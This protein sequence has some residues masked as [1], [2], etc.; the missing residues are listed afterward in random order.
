MFALSKLKAFADN[1]FKLI[2]KKENEVFFHRIE[3][4]VGKRENPTMFSNDVFL[5]ASKVLVMWRRVKFVF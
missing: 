2:Q 1:K 5:R 4:I 3:I